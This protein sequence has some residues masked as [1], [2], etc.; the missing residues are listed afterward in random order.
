[1]QPYTIQCSYAVYFHT[2]VSVEGASLED[3]LDKAVVAADASDAWKD[4]NHSG[5]IFVE[6]VSERAGTD[7]WC[8]SLAIP[9]RYTEHGREGEIETQ[10]AV[11][12]GDGDDEYDIDR[13]TELD[14][15]RKVL[16]T[17][18]QATRIDE[19]SVRV[20]GRAQLVPTLA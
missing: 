15:A 13:F 8:D 14:D 1:M 4:H 2:I 9:P 12:G 20:L 3:A 5:D 10:Y 19:I 6:A 7:P 17:D 11:V 16:A 18:G